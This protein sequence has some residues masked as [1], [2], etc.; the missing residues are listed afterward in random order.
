[1]KWNCRKFLKIESE[2]HES[3]NNK[4]AN[5]T[6]ENTEITV[7]ISNEYQMLIRNHKNIKPLSFIYKINKFLKRWYIICKEIIK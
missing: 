2:G 7:R 1:M 4:K 3:I 6:H 5:E